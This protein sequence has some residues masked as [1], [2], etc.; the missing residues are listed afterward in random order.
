MEKLLQV[1]YSFTLMLPSLQ[2]KELPI[3]IFEDVSSELWTSS[4]GSARKTKASLA[5]QQKFNI[6]DLL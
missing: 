5:S 2:R 1:E 4:Q 6:G 3:I